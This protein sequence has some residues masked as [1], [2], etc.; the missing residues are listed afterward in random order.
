MQAVIYKILPFDAL[1]GTTIRFSWS[2]N[3]VFKN[4]CIIKN[5]E[6]DVTV[7]DN[8]VPSFRLEHTIDLTKTILPLENGVKYKAFITVFDKNDRESDL[9]SLGTA[10]LCL[11]TPVLEFL[12]LTDGET[13]ASS[14]YT[15]SLNYTQE[16]GELLDSWAI[17]VYSRDHTLLS[18]SGIQY[19]TGQLS[20]P[21]SGFSNRSEYLIRGT[22]QTVNGLELDTGYQSISVLYDTYEIFSL[23]E[24]T[25]LRKTGAIH[26]KS[27][28]ISANGTLDQE[29]GVYIDGTA[30]DL[31]D[32][33]VTYKEGFLL[34]GD[35]SF[36]ILFRG[37]QPNQEILHLSAEDPEA[38]SCTVTYRIGKLGSEE[39]QGCFELKVVSHDIT[40]VYY[41]NKINLP[42]ETDRIG[43]NVYRS[44]SCYGIEAA[45]L[46]GDDS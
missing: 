19:E 44:Q 32:N 5:N 24:L 11:K 30:L 26:M 27:N 22:G 37:M 45:N 20:Y 9:Q 6:T 34:N 28:I 14:S 2:G 31:T 38:L 33:Q 10:F 36:V 13:I 16:D 1:I 3:Q 17:H 25:N 23:L 35:Y 46:G 21:F 42:S 40:S 12:D 7:Y 29:P 15:F 39:M 18:S 41:S 43:L 8:T 4:R